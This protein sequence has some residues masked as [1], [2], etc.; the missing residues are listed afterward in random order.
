MLYLAHALVT[1]VLI[2]AIMFGMHKT[3]LYLQIKEGGP[4]WSWPLFAAVGVAVFILNIL[5]PWPA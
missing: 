4:R 3:G 2:Y 1:G 5:W